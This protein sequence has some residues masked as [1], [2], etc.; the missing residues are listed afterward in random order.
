MELVGGLRRRLIAIVNLRAP[1][2]WP[3]RPT[4]V[5][6]LA[7][8]HQKAKG[9]TLIE[10]AFVLPLLLVF[11][12]FVVDLGI[13]LDRRELIQHAVREGARRAAVGDTLSNVQDTTHNQSAGALTNV[14]VCFVDKDGD[15]PGTGDSVRVSGDYTYK[16]SVGGGDILSVFGVGPPSIDMSQ[17]AE[18]RLETAATYLTECS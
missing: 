7:S 4:N 18:T 9:Q 14:Q 11:F 17:S 10:F 3:N 13:A 5:A 6:C 16:F 8:L 1:G 12:L 15:G 2:H